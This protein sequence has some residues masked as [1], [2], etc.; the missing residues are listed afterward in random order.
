MAAMR[1]MYSAIGTEL[2][3]LLKS[4]VAIMGERPPAITDASWYPNERPLYL[5]RVPKSSATK[6]A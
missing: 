3:V 4:P 2:P 5:T 6:L 1:I